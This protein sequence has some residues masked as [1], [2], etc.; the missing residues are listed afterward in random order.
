MF[1]FGASVRFIERKAILE[2]NGC[3]DFVKS[4]KKKK[5]PIHVNY[6]IN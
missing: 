6:K 2:S 1:R 3:R 4:P 5:E